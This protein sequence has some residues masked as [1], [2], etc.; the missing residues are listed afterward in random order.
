GDAGAIRIGLFDSTTLQS[1]EVLRVEGRDGVY[2]YAFESVAAGHYFIVA[3]ADL[4]NDSR[5]CS[6]AE[7]CGVYPALLDPATIALFNDVDSADFHLEVIAPPGSPAIPING[8]SLGSAPI[9]APVS[10]GN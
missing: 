3:G 8:N 1:V 10:T 5:L 4:N 7:P 9:G 6:L 2:P